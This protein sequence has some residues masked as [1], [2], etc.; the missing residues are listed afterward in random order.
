MVESQSQM[1][2]IVLSGI[3]NR[4]GVVYDSENPIPHIYVALI[5]VEINFYF[6]HVIRM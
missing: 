1:F 6:S 5:Q 3:V 2:G 4:D